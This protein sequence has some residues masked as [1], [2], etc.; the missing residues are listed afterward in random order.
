MVI[1]EIFK[2]TTTMV[3]DTSSLK[4]PLAKGMWHERSKH[5]KKK[6]GATVKVGRQ[7]VL[8]STPENTR[9]RK[10]NGLLQQ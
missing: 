5:G 7:S 3:Q 6:G 2:Y 9:Q 1:E 8:Q 4:W 10:I